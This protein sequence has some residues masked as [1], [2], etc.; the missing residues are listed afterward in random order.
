MNKFEIKI[1]FSSW[2]Y[3]WI[4]I[5]TIFDACWPVPSFD[6]II[7]AFIILFLFLEFFKASII[8]QLI[9]LALSI[10]GISAIIFFGE[11]KEISEGFTRARIF[12]V[13]FFAVSWLQIPASMSP[14]LDGARNVITNQPTGRRF[15]VASM[16]VHCLGAIL[17]LAGLSLVARMI[18]QADGQSLKRR[19]TIAL[20]LGFSSASCWSPF[21]ISMVVVLLA[22]PSLNFWDLSPFGVIF[23]QN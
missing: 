3:L 6:V 18:K 20:T 15:I 13:M 5:L 1:T 11:L 10:L 16:G 19:L 9:G 14:S 7:M 17:N 4:V 21:Y 12:L 22:I 23:V 2:L 8:A